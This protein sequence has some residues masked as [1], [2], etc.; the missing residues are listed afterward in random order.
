MPVC[1]C[2]AVGGE[3]SSDVIDSFHRLK[4]DRVLYRSFATVLLTDLPTCFLPAIAAVITRSAVGRL[5]KA[6]ESRINAAISSLATV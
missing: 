5:A 2:Y 6:G 1:E 3:G 4:K